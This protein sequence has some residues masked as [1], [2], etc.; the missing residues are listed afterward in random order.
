MTKAVD[1]CHGWWSIHYFQLAEVHV[2][3]IFETS[4]CNALYAILSC[5][6]LMFFNWM[7][8]YKNKIRFIQRVWHSEPIKELV[9]DEYSPCTINLSYT[10]FSTSFKAHWRRNKCGSLLVTEI[11]TGCCID[12]NTVAGCS[13]QRKTWSEVN[14]LFTHQYFTE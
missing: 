13:G 3:S 8:A 7:S 6:V 10:H 2:F 1:N 14:Y 12:K 5:S 9:M 11:L 4:Q